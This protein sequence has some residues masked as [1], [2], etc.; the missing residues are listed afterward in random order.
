MSNDYSGPEKL[1]RFDFNITDADFEDLQAGYQPKTIICNMEWSVKVIGENIEELI[2]KQQ[3]I[4]SL[5][6][7]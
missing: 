7:R 5:I 1:S 4:S 2:L 3:S 6:D